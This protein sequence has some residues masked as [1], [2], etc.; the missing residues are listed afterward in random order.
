MWDGVIEKGTRWCYVEE[1]SYRESLRKMVSPHYSSY[2]KR[3]IALSGAIKNNF[4]SEKIY[5]ELNDSIVPKDKLEENE[6][7]L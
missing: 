6:I 7:I 3:A 1:A 2:K 5:K 4:S